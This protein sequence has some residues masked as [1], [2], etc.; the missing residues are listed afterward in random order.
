[1]AWNDW[2]VISSPTKIRIGKMTAL[3][4]KKKIQSKNPKI[5]AAPTNRA[6]ASV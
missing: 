1:M 6:V 4:M 2:D 5:P 3:G